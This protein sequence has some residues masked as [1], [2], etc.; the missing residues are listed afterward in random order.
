MASRGY[1]GLGVLLHV[2]VALHVPRVVAAI[3]VWGAVLWNVEGATGWGTAWPYI[4]L[5]KCIS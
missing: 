1:A 2:A 4:G 3:V 5:V